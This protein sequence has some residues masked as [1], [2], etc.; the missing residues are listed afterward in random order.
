MFHSYWNIV[1]KNKL[2]LV[3]IDVVK[4]AQQIPPLDGRV[5]RFMVQF[6]RERKH[7]HLNCDV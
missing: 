5:L 1:R 6:A 4:D 3:R 2:A 7:G